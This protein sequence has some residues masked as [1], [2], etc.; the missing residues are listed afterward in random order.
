MRLER[1]FRSVVF[2]LGAAAAAAL[3]WQSVAQ[4]HEVHF[5]GRATGVN[6]TLTAQTVKK[7]LVLADVLMACT[8]TAREE[9]VSTISNPAP[10]GLNAR[11]VHGYTIGRDDVA[12]TN[13]GIDELHVNLAD[14]FKVDATALQS[15]AESRCDEA[16][17]KVVTSGSADVGSLFINGEG[18]ALTGE[19]NQTFEV[20]GMGKV[21][22][23]EQLKPSSREIIV[24][25]M[26]VIVADP[27]Y[28]ASGDIVFAHSR[29]KT[30]CSH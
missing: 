6:G 5:T 9:T 11:N 20:P 28:P 2:T 19:P 27:S 12:A 21:I 10:L 3:L 24:N 26:H 23:N 7:T 29:A 1:S 8:G 18:Q 15:N 14:G 22:V 25:A 16:T 4:S 13:A 17:L 30:T